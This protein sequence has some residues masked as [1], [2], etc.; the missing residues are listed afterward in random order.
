MKRLLLILL[1]PVTGLMAQSVTLIPTNSSWK[2]LANGTNQGTAWR[3]ISFAD[4][5]WS[6]GNAELGY[7][8][9]GEATVVSYGPSSFNKYITT[10]FRK[11]FTV[12]SPA[13]YSALSL[14]LLRDD[15]AVVY[16]NG[17]EIARSNM[18]TGTISYTT[19]ASS[20]ISG[21]GE[22]TY[23]TYTPAQSLLVTGTNLIA[24]EIHQSTPFTPDMSFNLSLTATTTATCG[25]PGSLSSS[26]ITSTGATINWSTVSGATS[27]N[28][29]YRVTGTGTWTTVSTTA[30]SYVLTGLLS[31]TS[32]EYSAQAVCTSV[33]GNYSANSTFSTSTSPTCGTPGSLTATSITT[34]GA[35]IGWGAVTGATTYNLRY[36]PTG[37]STWTTVSTGGTSFGLTGLLSSTT[38]EYS[39]QAVCASVP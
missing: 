12:S 38:Y 25:T 20:A 18:P 19:R 21:T 29:R 28:L 33:S 11:S 22:T 13:T 4:A 26:S 6:T 30:T 37:T 27:Y 23:Y 7:G 17:T 24:V 9:G 5:S 31:S 35:N 10:Y 15:G 16:L 1:L 36:R 39:V 2:Y 8:D 14:Q 32:Y 34:T 3:A